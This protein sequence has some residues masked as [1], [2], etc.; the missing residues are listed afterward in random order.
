MHRFFI[1]PLQESPKEVLLDKEE[2]YGKEIFKNK[3]LFR[4]SERYYE[5]I[6]EAIENGFRG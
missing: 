3:L 5:L 2:N 6:K 4:N 1:D